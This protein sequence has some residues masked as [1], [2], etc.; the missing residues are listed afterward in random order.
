MFKPPDHSTAGV[1]FEKQ[2]E[3]ISE[4]QSA[5]KKPIE[6]AV[7][8]PVRRNRGELLLHTPGESILV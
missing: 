5:I 6:R 8:P 7:F 4:C 1:R 2:P 3:L